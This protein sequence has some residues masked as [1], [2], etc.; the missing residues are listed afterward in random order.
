MERPGRIEEQH[1]DAVR[2]RL[3]RRFPEIDR[4][5][6]DRAIDIAH[7]RFDGRPVRDFV[8]LLVEGAATTILGGG[9]SHPAESS[10]AGVY[11]R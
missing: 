1:I 7:H 9:V 3:A 8:P 2:D 5:V 11:L 10:D 4:Y 6:V